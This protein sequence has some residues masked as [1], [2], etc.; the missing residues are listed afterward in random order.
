[1]PS[2][3]NQIEMTPEEVQ[4]F[5]DEP[6]KTLNIATIGPSGHPHL[7]AM[8]YAMHGANPVFWTFAKAQKVLNLRRGPM[9]SALVES[10]KTYST[11]KGVELVG[12]GRIVEDYDE[13]VAIA[14]AVGPR[15]NGPDSLTPAAVAFLENQARKRL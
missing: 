4:A 7:V 3:R 1:M 12:T 10:G 15:Y 6:G 5:L 9:M 13:I 2:R 14:K 8:W 11:L